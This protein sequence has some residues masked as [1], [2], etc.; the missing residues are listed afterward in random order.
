MWNE[1]RI[2]ALRKYWDQ[3]YSCSEIA[4][5]IGGVSKNSIIGKVHR[6]GLERRRAGARKHPVKLKGPADQK[7]AQAKVSKPKAPIAP[8][9]EPLPPLEPVTVRRTFEQLQDNECRWPSGDPKHDDFGFCGLP[10]VV[11]KPYCED[12]CRRAKPAH[13]TETVKFVIAGALAKL[14]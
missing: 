2:G 13:K 14:R 4:K 10:R 12:C 9:A 1:E 8:A 11:G 5:K 3:G 6:L 7:R